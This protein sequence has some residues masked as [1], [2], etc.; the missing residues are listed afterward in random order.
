MFF[1]FLSNITHR[2]YVENKNVCKSKLY[3][4]HWLLLILFVISIGVWSY[5]Y[6]NINIQM[7]FP[8][9]IGYLTNR[10]I[11]LLMLLFYIYS[12]YIFFFDRKMRCY[13]PTLIN[14]YLSMIAVYSK[15]TII[16]AQIDLS[17]SLSLVEILID[18]IIL[19]FS[20]LFLTYLCLYSY[21]KFI[22]KI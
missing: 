5:I 7:K 3:L 1:L 4:Y 16:G 14:H 9:S 13:Y 22:L 2:T 8:A 6:S 11:L 18:C 20:G 21:K 10:F 19:Y 17:I 15:L 12:I